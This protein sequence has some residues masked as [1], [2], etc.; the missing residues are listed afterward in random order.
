MLDCEGTSPKMRDALIGG[1]QKTCVLPE[2]NLEYL[3]LFIAARLA[4]LMFFYQGMALK[5]PQY[6]DESMKEIDQSAKYLK[7]VLKRIG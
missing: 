4:Q 1:Y 7:Y 5:F 3:D 2:S 6:T